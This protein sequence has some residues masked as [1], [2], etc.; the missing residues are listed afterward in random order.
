MG[1][2]LRIGMVVH[3]SGGIATGVGRYANRLIAGWPGGAGA[4]L[5]VYGQERQRAGLDPDRRARWIAGGAWHAIAA[6]DLAWHHLVLP[7]LAA[8]HRL[9]LLFVAVERRCPVIL[10]C[11]ALVTVHDLAPLAVP[12]KYGRGSRLLFTRLL[13][14][15]LRRHRLVAV[16]RMTA[17]DLGE[18]YGIPR[19]A[20][21]VIANGA[22]PVAAPERPAAWIAELP[23]PFVLY[24]ARLEHPGKNHVLAIAALARH[25]AA[26][27][28]EVVDLVCPGMAWQGVEAIHAAVAEHR[29]EGRV[30]IPGWISD[31]D[32]ACLYSAARALVFPSRY[33]GFG[34][35]LV[36]AMSRGLPIAATPCGA[37]PEVAGAAALYAGP[38]DVAGFAANL[39]RVLGDDGLRTTMAAVGRRRAGLF[40]WARS[41]RRTWGLMARWL[42]RRRRRGT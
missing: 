20:I 2:R 41:S 24:P 4:R 18:R 27:G 31:A 26:P 21:R 40:T 38:D 32:L 39:A 33:E 22:D 28:A 1:R 9:D 8:A 12:G 36:E 23:R 13:P 7:L 42:E 29:L 11:P 14:L 37:I 16:S 6:L 3:G 25:L 17:R 35:P 10:P 5:M 15:A 19:A 34:L 30:H